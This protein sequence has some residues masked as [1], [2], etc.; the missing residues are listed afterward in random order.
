VETWRRVVVARMAE[1]VTK[2]SGQGVAL[3]KGG[4]PSAE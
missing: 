3:E 1:A 2:G 4:V